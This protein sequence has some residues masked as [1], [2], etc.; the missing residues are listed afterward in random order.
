MNGK[1]HR[2]L[3]TRYQRCPRQ[4]WK[5]ISYHW[6]RV[7]SESSGIVTPSVTAESALSETPLIWHQ[8]CLEHCSFTLSEYLFFGRPHATVPLTDRRGTLLWAF[9]RFTVVKDMNNYRVILK[10][11]HLWDSNNLI[12]LSQAH[13]FMFERQSSETVIQLY[14]LYGCAMVL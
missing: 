8:Q 12:W 5:V 3:C 13:I 9:I 1:Q 10:T 14:F 4:C 6:C 7:S 2:L 11:R